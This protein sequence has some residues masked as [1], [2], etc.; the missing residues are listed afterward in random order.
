[1]FENHSVLAGALLGKSLDCWYFFSNAD[2]LRPFFSNNTGFE[3]QSNLCE[4]LFQYSSDL[5][6]EKLRFRKK[7]KILTLSWLQV[8]FFLQRSS[9]TRPGGGGPEKIL[10]KFI[11]SNFCY[12]LKACLGVSND[13]IR[14]VFTPFKPFIG[15]LKANFGL[16][17]CILTH[18]CSSYGD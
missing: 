10:E 17:N 14:S 13:H 5:W 8:S 7:Q 6:W 12:T 16:K 4:T 1:M 15:D 18:Q 3:I 11:F 9:D 2:K